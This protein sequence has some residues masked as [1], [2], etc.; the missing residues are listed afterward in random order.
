MLAPA[1]G[2]AGPYTVNIG[3]DLPDVNPGDGNCATSA[4][5]CTLHA[6]IQEANAGVASPD[7]INFI[8]PGGGVQTIALATPLPMITDGV[9][10]DATTQPGWMANTKPGFA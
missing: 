3:S 2:A 4:A 10:I 7:T 1:A 9:T 6:A 8:I 5:N